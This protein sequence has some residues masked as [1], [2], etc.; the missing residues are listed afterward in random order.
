MLARLYFAIAAVKLSNGAVHLNMYLRS[1]ASL[2][3]FAYL[4]AS[5]YVSWIP[6]MI[7]ASLWK[8][9]VPFP[10]PM[11]IFLLLHSIY[12]KVLSLTLIDV[13]LTMHVCFALQV[14][15]LH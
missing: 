3:V 2:C 11:H 14:F 8:F 12:V 7:V 5:L 1:L 15:E 6:G 4:S 13:S 10:P 9:W